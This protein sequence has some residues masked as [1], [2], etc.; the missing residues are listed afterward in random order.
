[1][2]SVRR[3][4]LISLGALMLVTALCFNTACSPKAKTQPEPFTAKLT[5]I[6]GVQ[7]VYTLRHPKLI[8]NELDKLM[9]EVP[10]AALLRMGLMQLT[11]FGYPE[12]SEIEAG[13]NI[14]VVM[15]DVNADE[16]K[17]AQPTLVAFAKLKEG[18]K[19]WS[20]LS[21]SGLALQKH[22]EWIWIAK[23][24]SSFDKIKSAEAITTFIAQPQTEEIRVWGRV[25]P[26]LL[27][28][29]KNAIFPQL[30]TKL[31]SR[32]PAEQKAAL[33]YANVL[34]GYLAQ[35]HS[36]GGSFDLNDQGLSLSYYGQFLPDSA[37]GRFL[38][39]AQSPSPKIAESIPA[40]GLFSVVVRQNMHGQIEFVTGL[41]DT[42]SAVPYPSGSE[43]LKSAKAA[44]LSLSEHND[45]GAVISMNMSLPKGTQAPELDMLGVNT[46]KFTEAEIN[47]AYK[48]MMGLSKE[49]TNTMLLAASSL[50]P[51]TPAPGIQQELTENALTIDGTKFGSIVTTTT[52]SVG[53]K[54]QVTKTTQYYGVVG[55]NLVYASS[56][57]SLRAKLPAIA[58][59]RP[60]DH[61]IKL[62]LQNDEVAVMAIHGEKIVDTVVAGASFDA[63][64]TDIQAQIKTLKDGYAAGE[65][66]KATVTASQAKAA[67]T[68]SIPYKFV[69][70]SVRL[71]QFASAYKPTPT[72]TNGMPQP[73][74]AAASD[75]SE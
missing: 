30:E 23:D 37:T 26:A 58:A 71:F 74:P 51:A 36:G 35:L 17:T 52:M 31:A 9:V 73:A 33:D 70:Q 28:A 72:Q 53:G 59:K 13:S 60:V 57:A 61:P 56:E 10:E 75:Q 40:D 15:L 11:A 44:Y 2:K 21:Q 47:A 63:A 41:L 67:V 25:S 32:T 29:A 1:M 55:G 22:G 46:G 12:F 64:D 54:D 50:N 43:A 65:P 68:I 27:A 7:A 49:F 14:G 3:F 69:S 39:Y 8:S 6:E 18:G 16:L 66:V 34:W 5:E 62:T 42:L 45:G 20:L 19:I 38:R 24:A 48:N 4:S